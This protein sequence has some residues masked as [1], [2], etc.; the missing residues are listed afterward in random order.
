MALVFRHGGWALAGL[1]VATLTVPTAAQAE[2]RMW[3]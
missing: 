2:R 3:P 1:I